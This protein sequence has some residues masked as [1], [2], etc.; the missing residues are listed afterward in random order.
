MTTSGEPKLPFVLTYAER[1]ERENHA[2]PVRYHGDRQLSQI[3]T[4]SGWVDAV[5]HG[6]VLAGTRHTDV[7]QETTDDD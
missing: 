5:T 4:D 6:D 3:F 7:S 2:P 1:I